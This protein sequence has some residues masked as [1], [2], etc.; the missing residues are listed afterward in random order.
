MQVAIIEDE[1]PAAR[2]LKSMLQRLRPDW[3]VIFIPGSIEEAV[4]WFAEHQHPDL[5]FLDIQLSDGNSFLFLQNA[6]PESA[7]IFTTAYDEYA[8]KAFEVN[9]IDYLLKPIHQDR[10]EVSIRR[11]EDKWSLKHVSFPSE[12]WS[13]LLQII[14]EKGKK[15]RTRFLISNGSKLFTLQLDDVA[16]FYSKE[17]MTFAM[18][19]EGKAY[20]VDFSLDKLGEQLD[21]DLFFRVNRQFLLN[22][23]C[24]IRIEPYFNNKMLVKVKPDFE[25]Q[26]IISKEKV[27]MLKIW[28]NF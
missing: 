13:E 2:L 17:K 19:N 25:G 3:E 9:S 24:I 14:N 10:L 7:V 12:K 4:K 1:M 15:Y 26:I 8:V 21:P 27:A 11:F 20:I 18:T 22:V 6:Q 16:Y 5:I 23:H 28:L